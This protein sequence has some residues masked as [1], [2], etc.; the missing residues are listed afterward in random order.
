MATPPPPSTDPERTGPHGAP[1]SPA[2]LPRPPSAKRWRIA[3]GIGIAL[4]GH[5][6]AS[7]LWLLSFYA[8][9]YDAS[10]DS[11]FMV[12]CLV[13][14]LQM[15]LFAGCAV[16]GSVMVI[17]GDRGIG[18]GMLVGWVTGI[19]ALVLGTALIA[20]SAPAT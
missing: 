13:I 9:V 18:V 10:P 3:A 14:L 6:P 7:G 1:P 12:G 16:T 8:F 11:L 17:R 19:I 15:A 2:D 4:A 5:L 20:Y